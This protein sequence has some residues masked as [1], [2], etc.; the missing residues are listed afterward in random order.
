MTKKDKTHNSN[1]EHLGS[2]IVSVRVLE[3]QIEPRSKQN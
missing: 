2:I 1:N 3:Q